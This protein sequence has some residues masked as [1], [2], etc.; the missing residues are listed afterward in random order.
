MATHY[1]HA[2]GFMFLLCLVCNESK[3][4]NILQDVAC[5]CGCVVGYHVILPLAKFWNLRASCTGLTDPSPTCISRQSGHIRIL[6][7]SE[8][9]PCRSK[10]QGTAVRREKEAS[11]AICRFCC[12][13]VVHPP[14]ASSEV[15]SRLVSC[16]QHLLIGARLTSR[17]LQSN[18]LAQ[19]SG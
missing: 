18:S 9:R 17:N 8:L 5:T 6:C 10:P 19:D 13:G 2:W 12:P 7:K 4:H 15:L 1:V 16:R 11:L 14:D 3:I